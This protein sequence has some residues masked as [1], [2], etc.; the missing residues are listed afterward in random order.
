MKQ[1]LNESNMQIPYW[2][3]KCYMIEKSPSVARLNGVKIVEFIQIC[4]KDAIMFLE[5]KKSAPHP[6]N[7]DNYNDYIQDIRE[8]F[9]NSISL[10]NAAKMKRREDIFLELPQSLKDLDYKAMH[11]WLYLVIKDAKDDWIPNLS[12]DLRKQLHPF[13]KSWNIPDDKFIVA[14]E[15][16]AKVIGIVE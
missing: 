2:D 13:L 8:K 16:M 12:N 10:L 11:Y 4:K 9:Q 7:K 1:I 14:N 5:A 6:N 3:D 15:G